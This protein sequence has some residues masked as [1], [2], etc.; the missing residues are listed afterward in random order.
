MLKRQQIIMILSILLLVTLFSGTFAHENEL[1]GTHDYVLVS[2]F[3]DAMKYRN[4]DL[5][6]YTASA[7][8]NV[9]ANQSP[10]KNIFL[11][12]YYNIVVQVANAVQAKPE[13]RKK[14]TIQGDLYEWVADDIDQDNTCKGL[15]AEAEGKGG[16]SEYMRVTVQGVTRFVTLRHIHHFS[17][18]QWEDYRPNVW[19]D[20]TRE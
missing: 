6:V 3:A 5:G 20:S 19:R 7:S 18:S 2:G 1:A 4:K 17:L 11:R 9:E 14:G 16:A 8:C 15:F 12:V 13:V 10:H